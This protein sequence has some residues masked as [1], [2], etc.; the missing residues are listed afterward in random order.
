MTEVIFVILRGCLDT[1]ANPEAASGNCFRKRSTFSV[2]KIFFNFCSYVYRC[3]SWLIKAIHKHGDKKKCI[4]SQLICWK[5]GL[6]VCLKYMPV[7][8]K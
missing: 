1:D 8:Q 3:F 2:R 7:K 4:W 6:K 5:D